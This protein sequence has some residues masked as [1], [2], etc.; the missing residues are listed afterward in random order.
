MVGVCKKHR[1]EIKDIGLKKKGT[2][3]FFYKRPQIDPHFRQEIVQV[4]RVFETHPLEILEIEK[5]NT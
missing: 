1:S 5:K 4:R 2:Y 3:P